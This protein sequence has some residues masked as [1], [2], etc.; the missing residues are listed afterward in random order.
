MLTHWR[1]ANHWNYRNPRTSFLLHTFQLDALFTEV[2]IRAPACEIGRYYD[3]RPPSISV[4]QRAQL[5]VELEISKA[6]IGLK[7]VPHPLLIP[8]RRAE[9]RFICANRARRVI[10]AEGLSV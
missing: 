7:N 5:R 1:P 6:Q 10:W 9:Y 2:G 4:Y 3:I 8:A